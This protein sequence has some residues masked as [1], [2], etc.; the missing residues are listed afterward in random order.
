MKIKLIIISLLM[1][2]NCLCQTQVNLKSGEKLEGE[3][4]SLID[5]IITLN[6]KGNILTLKQNE[7]ESIFFVKPIIDK[8]IQLSQNE[9]KGEFRGVVTY[10]FNNNYGDKPDVGATVYF[11]KVDTTGNNRSFTYK[12]TQANYCRN[13]KKLSDYCIKLLKE[14]DADT[15]SGFK[16]L[17]YQTMEEFFKMEIY[18]KNINKV[19]VDGSGNYSTKVEPGLYEVF[20]KSKGRNGLGL[21]ETSGKIASR[22][23]FVKAGEVKNIDIRFGL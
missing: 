22:V 12:F 6:F 4:K 17:N 18:D 3:V 19:T 20:F 2:I 9:A 21:A 15:D 8:T 13:E 10:F 7:I 11:K 1:S 14:V 23:Y 16:K 5:G